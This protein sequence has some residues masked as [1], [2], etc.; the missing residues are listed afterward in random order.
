MQKNSVNKVFL[1]GHLGVNPEGR[2]TASG[3]P[4]SSFSL[5]TNEVWKKD[6]SKAEEHT[7]W[8][9]IV[10]WDRLA[11]FVQEYLYKGQLVSIEGQIRSHLWENKE[12]FKNKKTEIIASAITPLEWNSDKK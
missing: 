6:G 8:H 11:D 2:Y 4:V 9:N 1:V 5:A 3:R 10:V 12:G 7:E